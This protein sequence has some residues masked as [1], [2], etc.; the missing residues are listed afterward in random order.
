MSLQVVVYAEGAG[1]RLGRRSRRFE[2]P[3]RPG[4]ALLEH[5]DELGAAHY[6]ARRAVHQ[7]S[8]I[9]EHAVQFKEPL[10]HRGMIATG[11]HLTNPVTLSRLLV[12]PEPS[13]RPELAV[14]F[15]DQDAQKQ[16]RTQ[17]EAAVTKLR[18]TVKRVIAVAVQEFEAWLIADIAAVQSVLRISI[19]E[20]AS[21]EKMD[22]REAKQLLAEWIAQ[23]PRAHEDPLVI[24]SDIAK[25]CELGQVASRCSSF[26]RLLDGLEEAL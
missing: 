6:L 8:A 5:E 10:R 7:V 13:L 22:P 14:V 3:K 26:Q 4:D 21:P 23:S 24:R 2:L 25:N 12:W 16:R 9:P 1:E 17:L 18:P 11:S 19:D 20:A 15:V